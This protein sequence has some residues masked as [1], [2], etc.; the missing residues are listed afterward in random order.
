MNNPRY[1]IITPVRNEESFLEQTIKSVLAQT[2]KPIQWIIVNDGS[3]DSTRSIIERYLSNKWITV[4]DRP[5]KGHRA[6]K[7]PAEAF[8]ISLSYISSD[9]DFIVNLDGDVSFDSDYFEKI[10][11]KFKNNSCLGIASGKSYYLKRGKT[12]LYRSSDTSTMGPSKVYRKECF[13]DIGGVLE[14]NICWDMLDNIR[15]QMKGW[16]TKSFG[17]I[18]FIHYKQIGY[19]QGS[20]LKGCYTTGNI[21]YFYGYH[22]LYILAKGIYRM[23]ESPFI[24]G[25]LYTIIGYYAAWFTRKDRY[26][27]K[28][29]IAYM[30]TK[31]MQKLAAQLFGR[32]IMNRK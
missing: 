1:I 28:N 12:V 22:P 5:N 20:I 26:H 13:L 30:Q 7:G 4:I 24:I 2:I 29:L 21:L 18:S 25:G 31:Q 27:D 23:C 8:N 3:T 14:E 16:D 17:D 9:Y 32:I 11:N 10:F 6:G 19:K 15:A